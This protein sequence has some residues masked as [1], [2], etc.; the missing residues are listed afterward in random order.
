MAGISLCDA[1]LKDIAR[2]DKPSSY[3]VCHETGGLLDYNRKVSQ[4]L[5][6]A[7]SLCVHVNSSEDIQDDTICF[8]GLN[9]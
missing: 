5:S 9:C 1:S 8:T 6:G 4:V 3:H 2:V 7:K